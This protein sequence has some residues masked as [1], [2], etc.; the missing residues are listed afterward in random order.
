MWVTAGPGCARSRQLHSRHLYFAKGVRDGVNAPS[1]S[2][3]AAGKLC[4]RSCREGKREVSWEEETIKHAEGLRRCKSE[5]SPAQPALPEM[6]VELGR[7][8][9]EA[10]ALH[11]F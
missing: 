7:P 8:S 2:C 1:C 10:D 11:P 4:V 6:E 5:R 3:L 9:E